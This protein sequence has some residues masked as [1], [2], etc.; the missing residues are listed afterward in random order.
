VYTQFVFSHVD[1]QQMKNIFF[2][3]PNFVIF[4]QFIKTLRNERKK[5]VALKIKSYNFEG[6]H[7]NIYP[8]VWLGTTIRL[9]CT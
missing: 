6:E 4:D 9:S 2:S 3:F 5:K 1:N 7:S 8:E